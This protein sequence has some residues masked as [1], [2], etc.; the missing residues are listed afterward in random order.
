MMTEKNEKETVE[1]NSED[2]DRFGYVPPNLMRDVEE[3]GYVPPAIERHP[4]P[5]SSASGSSTNDN[6]S[7]GE[8]PTEEQE[9]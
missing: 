8:Q 9:Q 3:R 1:L 2:T 7:S 6:Q 4:T 5:M